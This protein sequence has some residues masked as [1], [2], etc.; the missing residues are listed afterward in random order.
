MNSL[1]QILAGTLL[2]FSF[3]LSEVSAQSFSES[4]LKEPD[5]KAYALLLRAE[6]FEGVDTNEGGELSELVE[7]Y[8]LLLQG[9]CADQAFESLLKKSTIPGQ[10]YALCGLYFTDQEHFRLVVEKYRHND[11]VVPTQFGCVVGGMPISMLVESKCSNVVRLEYPEQS[12]QEWTEKHKAW[13]LN[14]DIIGGG[15]PTWFRDKRP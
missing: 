11:E 5:R 4:Q 9:P 13:T 10:L 6:R 15:Y 2:V 1:I 8:R 14:F 7:A 12:L 3:S